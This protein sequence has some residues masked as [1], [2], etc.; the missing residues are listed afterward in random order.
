MFALGAQCEAY[1]GMTPEAVGRV[2]AAR[3]WTYYHENQPPSR[4]DKFTELPTAYASMN[5]DEDPNAVSEAEEQP[6]HYRLNFLGIFAVPALVD[7]LLL[8]FVGRGLYLSTFMAEDEKTM[9]TAGLMVGLLLVGGIGTWVGHGGSY[10]LHGMTFPAMNMFVLSRLIA[11]LAMSLIVG[12]GALVVLGCIKNF[13]AGFIFLF[14]FFSLST[15]LTMLATLAVYQ[16]PGFKFQSGRSSVVKCIP[17]LLIS[18]IATS[19]AGHD[20]IVYPIVLS[21][22]LGTLIYSARHVF[23]QWHSWYSTVPVVGDTELVHWFERFSTARD[24]N[25]ELP[26][27]DLAAT[28]LPRTAL[29]VELQRERNRHPWTKS[30]A[31]DFVKTIARGHDATL[32]LMDWYC[33][34]S[35]T[36]M[37]YPY[38]PT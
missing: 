38:S 30:T 28:P 31:D 35:R 15:Y 6:F 32:L 22:F 24:K 7:I 4:D 14:Y 21:G 19:F 17:L 27:I 10:Y 8:T 34:Y 12:V 1:L 29:M 23:A 13:Y 26:E 9:A 18:P 11:G 2:L 5:T 20:I 16:F 33:K 36:K 3:Y 37:P 25:M